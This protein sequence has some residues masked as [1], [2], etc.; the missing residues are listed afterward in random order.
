MGVSD[1]MKWFSVL[2][3]A[4]LTLVKD[5]YWTDTSDHS[6]GWKKQNRKSGKFVSNDEIGVPRNGTSTKMSEWNEL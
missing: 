3:S 6:L 1:V 4:W 5:K 2:E